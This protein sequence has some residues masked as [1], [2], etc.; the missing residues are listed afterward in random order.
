MIMGSFN[1]LSSPDCFDDGLT[2][3]ELRFD[4]NATWKVECLFQPTMPRFNAQGTSDGDQPD[5][6]K[7]QFEQKFVCTS[8]QSQL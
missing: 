6:V 1:G 4:S 3:I 7:V 5:I 2:S 8:N